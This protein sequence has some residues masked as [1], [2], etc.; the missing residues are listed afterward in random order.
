LHEYLRLIEDWVTFGRKAVDFSGGNQNLHSMY[1]ALANIAGKNAEVTHN[2]IV[3][4]F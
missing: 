4:T 1:I 3:S 2:A